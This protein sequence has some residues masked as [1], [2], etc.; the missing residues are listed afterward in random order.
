MSAG[1][2][3]CEGSLH[4]RAA[5]GLLLFNQ[6]EFFEAHEAL[7]EAWL[8]EPGPL[9]NLYQGLLQAA[10]V[11]LHI[12]RAN[13]PGAVKVHQRCMKWLAGWPE[14]CRGV[15]VGRL[16]RDL[17]EAV[18]EVQRLV[19]GRLAAFDPSLFRPV[20]FEPEAASSQPARQERRYTCDLCGHEMFESNCKAICPNCGNR[21]DCSDLNLH[22]D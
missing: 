20:A 2:F 21:F 15:R 8:A 3:P 16:R 12:Q 4:P 6:R 7:E 18:A 5:A 19:E 17:D 14:T 9:R 10:V 11:Y 1:G 13:Y 22:F